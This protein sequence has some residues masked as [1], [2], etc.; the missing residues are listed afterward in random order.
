MPEPILN[1]VELDGHLWRDPKLR[2]V[3]EKKIALCKFGIMNGPKGRAFLFWG[4][5]WEEN[6]EA[7]AAL[8]RGDY[9]KM[10][11]YLRSESWEDKTTGKTQ[12][13]VV[14][15]VNEWK[16]LGDIGGRDVEEVM[17]ELEENP[18]SE[19]EIPF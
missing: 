19:D 2:Y 18:A 9:L 8:K 17:N 6:A 14:I 11:G 10:K 16:G 4:Q 12:Y 3:G 7:I 1:Y 13:K 5:A 15:S